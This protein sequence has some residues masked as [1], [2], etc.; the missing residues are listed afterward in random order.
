[1]ATDLNKFIPICQLTP[2]M[3]NINLT[4][5]VLEVG[6]L[7]QEKIF[8]YLNL[9]VANYAERSNIWKQLD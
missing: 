8:Q 6:W 3:K 9:F 2:N 7:L 5:I 1:M 4:F